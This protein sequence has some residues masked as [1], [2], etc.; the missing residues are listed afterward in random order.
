VKNCRATEVRV[1]V[2]KV[3]GPSLDMGAGIYWRHGWGAES[4]CQGCA[5]GTSKQ[6]PQQGALY[7]AAAACCYLGMPSLVMDQ[8]SHHRG[9]YS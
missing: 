9:A 2:N 8:D 3:V 5:A 1:T 7:K 4:A 6:Q